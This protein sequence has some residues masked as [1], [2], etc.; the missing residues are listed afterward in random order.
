MFP[1]NKGLGVQ[2]G[3]TSLERTGNRMGNNR[4]N[5]IF[6]EGKI[7]KIIMA[8]KYIVYQSLYIDN[9]SLNQKR[10]VS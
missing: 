3:G 6:P 5:I 7:K 8:A 10:V 2:F 1:K 9:E 4:V